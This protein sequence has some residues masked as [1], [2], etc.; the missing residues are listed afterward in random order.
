VPRPASG[1]RN[2]A[3]QRIPG[4]TSVC[5]LVGDPDGLIH[6][7]NQLGLEGKDH[8]DVLKAAAAAGTLVHEA[9]EAL[10]QGRPYT[11]TGDPDVVAKAR[12]GFRAFEEWAAQTR[13]TVET[14]ELSL[15][16]ECYQYGTT[17]DATV[18]NGLR[19]VCEYK[20][21]A[22]VYPEHL[23]QMAAQRHAWECNFPDKPIEGGHHLIRFQ[24]DSGDFAHSW[25]GDLSEA[26]TAFVHCR[27]LYDLKAALKR[28]CR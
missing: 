6:W 18:I 9:A 4:N 5:K 21:A 17:L 27:A 3:G 22:S 28:R 19:A 24:R 8:R 23:L 26:W 7:A 12:I 25:Y 11:F 2:K 15:I 14:A 1:Y 10:G 20:T 16:C 13:L